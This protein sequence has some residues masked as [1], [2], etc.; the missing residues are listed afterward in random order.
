MIVYV[1][2]DRFATKGIRLDR[3]ETLTIRWVCG[4]G[5][6]VIGSDKV[7][8]T[9]GPEQPGPATP[10]VVLVRPGSRTGRSDPM[11]VAHRDGDDVGLVARRNRLDQFSPAER[12]VWSAI[13]AVEA[14]DADVR[15]TE[16]VV[17]L[18]RA[19]NRVADWV[20]QL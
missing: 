12:A 3:T 16:A 19:Q 1:A 17:L 5:E 15:L 2:G 14:L 8:G 18:G 11:A 10:D 6:T 9:L 20:D 7:V 4:G 13:Q